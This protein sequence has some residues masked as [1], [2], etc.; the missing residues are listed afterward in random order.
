MGTRKKTGGLY[1]RGNTWHI[2]KQIRGERI[3][4]STGTSDRQKAEQILMQLMSTPDKWDQLTGNAYTFA[5]AAMRWAKD[6]AHLK[7]IER[8]IQDLKQLYPYIGHLP[9][10]QVHQGTLDPYIN[11]RREAGIKSSTLNRALSTVKRV[12]GAANT[13]YRDEWGEPWLDHMPAFLTLK[14]NDKRPPYPMSPEEQECLLGALR[15]SLRDIALFALHTGLRDH[16][17]THLSWA[18]EMLSEQG[19]LM[20]WLPAEH[21][22]NGRARLVVCNSVAKDLVEAR[23]G[24]TKDYIFEHHEG[25]ARARIS[26]GS[27]WKAGRSRAVRMLEEATGKPATDGFKSL[28]FHDLRHTF[29]S[30]LMAAEVSYDVRRQILGHKDGDITAHYCKVPNT[31][32]IDAVKRLEPPKLPQNPRKT[33]LVSLPNFSV[34]RKVLK[35]KGEMVATG[36]LEPPT[37]AL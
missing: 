24:V 9:L 36:G 14:W 22:K 18:D 20:F 28:H 23:R 29:G 35:N 10:K 13:I 26:S 21:A 15:G 34:A 33:S 7:S 1:L 25:K 17:L 30:H 27:G 4:R 37:P 6:N 2:D 11:A 32:L 8:D 31:Q 19:C 5:D 16:E 3:C 12:L